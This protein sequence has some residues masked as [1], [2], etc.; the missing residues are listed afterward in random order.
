MIDLMNQKLEKKIFKD[1]ESL[2]KSAPRE[3]NIHN[4]SPKKLIFIEVNGEYETTFIETEKM[5]YLSF[6]KNEDEH[7]LNMTRRLS[8]LNR[9]TGDE[10]RE[11]KIKAR[12]DKNP[13]L[14]KDFEIT[15]IFIPF[16]IE[17]N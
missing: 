8:K 1:A 15:F 5:N 6:D 12:K 14:D 4:D 9:E 10:M 16:G 2:I 7:L 13:F 17:I 11:Y 3:L